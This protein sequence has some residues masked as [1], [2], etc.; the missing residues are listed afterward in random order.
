VDASKAAFHLRSSVPGPE[1]ELGVCAGES[2]GAG[3]AVQELLQTGAEGP[4]FCWTNE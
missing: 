4:H 1:A 3:A 2:D